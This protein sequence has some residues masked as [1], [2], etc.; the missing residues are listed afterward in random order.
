MPELNSNF[1]LEFFNHELSV[2]GLA[3]NETIFSVSLDIDPEDENV[4]KTIN[5]TTANVYGYYDISQFDETSFKYVNEGG[6]DKVKFFTVK[7]KDDVPPEDESD[8]FSYTPDPSNSFTATFTLT[9]NTSQGTN[10]TTYIKTIF[11]DY[12][13]GRDFIRERFN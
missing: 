6:S 3:N 12:D 4:L 1:V 9:A 7:D 5:N 8:L 2:Q 10:I 13:V 11:N